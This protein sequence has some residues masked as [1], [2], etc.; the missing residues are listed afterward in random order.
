M[1]NIEKYNQ[2]FVE[3]FGVNE[4]VLN[5]SFAKDS[6]DGW[7]SVHQLNIIALLEESFDIMFDPE[8]I[9]EFTS[10]E[11]GKIILGKYEVSL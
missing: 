9:M 11:K 8:D 7:D 4:S 5:D 6:V 1:T 10:Y 3:V 2:A